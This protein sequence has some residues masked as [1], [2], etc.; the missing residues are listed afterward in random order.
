VRVDD[1]AK[2]PAR[3]LTADVIPPKATK[4]YRAVAKAKRAKVKAARA[5][6]TAAATPP[7]G[8]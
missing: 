6:R 4:T 1:A 2:N 5:A 8:T 3:Y 7:T